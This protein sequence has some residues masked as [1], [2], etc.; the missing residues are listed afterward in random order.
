MAGGGQN[1]VGGG[2]SPPGHVLPL[3][4]G[5]CGS[6]GAGSGG[7]TRSRG[8]HAGGHLRPGAPL[9]PV[10]QLGVWSSA[11]RLIQFSGTGHPFP[12]CD[13]QGRR[14]PRRSQVNGAAQGDSARRPR[15]GSRVTDRSG[16]RGCGAWGPGSSRPSRATPTSGRPC[17][18]LLRLAV[19]LGAQPPLPPPPK[20]PSPAPKGPREAGGSRAAR[21]SS[22]SHIASP[23]EG[24]A[25]RHGCAPSSRRPDL[26]HPSSTSRLGGPSPP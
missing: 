19:S 25:S 16:A 18:C 3:P 2:W 6:L 15:A 7:S 24:R 1:P 21:T 17:V 13:R 5:V 11:R 12:L 14:G 4:G 26:S 20:R 10:P 23:R 22:A 9:R 8:R